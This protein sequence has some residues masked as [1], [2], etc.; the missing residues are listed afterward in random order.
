[1]SPIQMVSNY[2]LFANDGV[3]TYP[4][5]IVGSET[6]TKEIFKKETIDT[7]K[8]MLVEV[9]TA[10]EGTA[11]QLNG[12]G[13]LAAKTGTAELKKA[14]GERGVENSLISVFDVK[15]SRFIALSIVEDHREVGKTAPQLIKPVIEYLELLNQ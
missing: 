15:D 7:I 6:K 13:N 1:M 4:N 9:V 11:H 8:P 5:L 2:S 10:A 3:L 14:Q 12:M